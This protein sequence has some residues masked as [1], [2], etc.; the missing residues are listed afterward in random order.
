VI[1]LFRVARSTPNGH[2]KS[3]FFGW[4]ERKPAY[5]AIN[6]G[7][8]DALKMIAGTRIPEFPGKIARCEILVA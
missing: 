2:P 6:R 5:A 7:T 4:E 1:W 8:N 3:F